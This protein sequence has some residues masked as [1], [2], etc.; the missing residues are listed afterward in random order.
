M[1]CLASSASWR[2][3]GLSRCE[4]AVSRS[5]DAVRVGVASDHAFSFYYEDNLDL[6]RE[7]G[8]E[9][10]RFSP[11]NDASLPSGLDALYLG[12]G[13]PELYAEQLSGNRQ[14]LEEVRAFAASGR[15]VYAECGGMLYLSESLRR[16]WRELCDGRRAAAFDGD[17]RQTG[18]VWIR[19]GGVHRGLPAGTQGNGCS[20]A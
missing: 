5:N 13:Y 11:L 3:P 18:S 10:V 17:D 4:P 14:M 15:P 16:R 19:H 8:A 2:W 20:R 7:Q 6:L 12:G 1:A 9:I